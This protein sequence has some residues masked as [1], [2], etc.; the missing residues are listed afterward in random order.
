MTNAEKNRTFLSNAN[1][2]TKTK[3]LGNISKHYNIS[4]SEALAEVYHDE[5]EHLPE[6]MTGV[7]RLEIYQSMKKEGL[8]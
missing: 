2:W 8:A 3:A 7:E 6:Y 4:I 1:A 5:A